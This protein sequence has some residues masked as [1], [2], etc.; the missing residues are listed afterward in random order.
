MR[1]THSYNLGQ[2]FVERLKAKPKLIF[3]IFYK[4]GS[5]A[6][7]IQCCF[8]HNIVVPD[9]Q[10]LQ[11]REAMLRGQLHGA[12]STPGLNSDLLTEL[13]FFTITWKISTPGLKCF[14]PRRHVSSMLADPPFCFL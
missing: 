11:L 3:V 2:K 10:L 14:L 4:Y 9:F 8:R 5:P 12:F 13:K 1:V 6:H 7:N